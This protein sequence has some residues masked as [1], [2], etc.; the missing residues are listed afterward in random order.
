MALGSLILNRVAYYFVRQYN[1]S[2]KTTIYHLPLASGY[3]AGRVVTKLGS[4]VF[5]TDLLVA[6][7]KRKC[8][9]WTLLAVA[10]ERHTVDKNS[11][12]EVGHITNTEARL[13][14]WMKVVH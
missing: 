4:L 8:S 6:S 2:S 3:L 14:V 5:D 7:S 12:K 9:H 13:Y 11:W 1:Q 10:T